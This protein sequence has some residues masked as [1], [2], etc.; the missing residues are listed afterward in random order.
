MIGVFITVRSP[1]IHFIDSWFVEEAN[2]ELNKATI[3]L[4]RYR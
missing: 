2:I 3:D 4:Y 1:A